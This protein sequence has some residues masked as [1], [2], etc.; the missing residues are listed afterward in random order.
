[1]AQR[2]YD[3]LVA[4]EI[5]VDFILSGES[6][7][8]V[9]GQESLIEDATLTMGSSTIIFACGAARLGLKVAVIG[10]V[11]QDAFGDFMLQGMRARG[12][13]TRW[14]RQ[15]AEPRTGI[16][17][18]LSE[19]HDRAMLTYA[20]TIAALRAEDVLD[21]QLAMARHFHV[22]A[23][24][25]QTALLPDLGGLFRRAKAQGCTTSMDTGW[26]PAEKWN[27]PI[28]DAL[29]AT[30]IFMPNEEEAPRIA[31]E[32]SPTDAARWLARRVPTVTVKLGGD[33][34]L[35]AKGDKL[36]RC[37]AFPVEVVDTTGAGDSFDAGLVYAYL[38]GWGEQEA[39]E[40]ACACGALSTRAAGGTSSQ[41]TLEEALALVRTSRKGG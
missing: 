27:G 36:Y 12:L 25:L 28:H 38:S 1:M 30:D 33:G 34:A 15:V 31:K 8:P 9:F 7:R 14:V 21:E 16:T 41:A 23:A 37:S 10:L 5:N 35:L 6:V 3:L 32:A 24:F 22:S 39:L 11:G 29:S 4:A 19:P 26:D 40:L 2:P 17:V 13:D 20:G 18:S